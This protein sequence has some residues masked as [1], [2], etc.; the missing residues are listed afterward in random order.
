MASGGISTNGGGGRQ[1]ENCFYIIQMENE[2]LTW[3]KAGYTYDLDDRMDK[4]E[5]IGRC[6]Q[7]LVFKDHFQNVEEAAAIERI[8]HRNLRKL[9]LDPEYMKNYMA[10]GY[11]ECYQRIHLGVLLLEYYRIKRSLGIQKEQEVV[12]SGQVEE[13]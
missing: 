10:N 13:V 8:F 4:Y 9:K 7:T 2:H 3:L 6:K 5:F 11:S 1:V 12:L